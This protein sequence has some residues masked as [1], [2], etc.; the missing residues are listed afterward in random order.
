MSL[1][2]GIFS[3]F[4]PSSLSKYLADDKLDLRDLQLTSVSGRDW[5]TILQKTQIVIL[6]NN[7]LSEI[8]LSCAN[9]LTSISA[10]NNKLIDFP[11]GI[12]NCKE[13]LDI[14]FASNEISQISDTIW[15]PNDTP[16]LRSLCLI[17]NKILDVSNIYWD[18]KNIVWL[19]LSKNSIQKFPN[20]LENIS[21]LKE[22]YLDY[23]EIEE[24][25]ENISQLTNLQTLDI[26]HNKITKI[27]PSV[28]K[29]SSLRSLYFQN[30]YVTKLEDCTSLIYLQ[31]L[32]FSNN[33]ITSL[34]IHFIDLPALRK[35]TTFGNENIQINREDF[36]K[37]P[38]YC[39][40]IT[41][42]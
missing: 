20:N 2:D 38:K 33:R 41:S 13:L 10:V 34:P 17:E 39:K 16:K 29:I 21:C 26:S 3:F 32:N 40:L 1:L 37:L 18:L 9:I 35:L 23:N 14:N 12:A 6:D 11:N 24:I 19:A 30:N 28:F 42:E 4:Q 7:N 22:L 31:Y 36:S 27:H 8:D 5:N 25:E 15:K